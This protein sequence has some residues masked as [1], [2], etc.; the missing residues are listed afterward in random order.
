M[1]LWG[2]LDMVETK[3]FFETF[4]LIAAA[5]SDPDALLMFIRDL[6]TGKLHREFHHG[7]DPTAPPRQPVEVSS[8][9]F[10]H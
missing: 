5:F 8:Y 10:S 1:R 4:G 3:T 2:M 9:T 7:P 6:H